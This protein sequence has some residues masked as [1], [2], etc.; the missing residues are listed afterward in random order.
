MLSAFQNQTINRPTQTEYS[1]QQKTTVE[2]HS[3]RVRCVLVHAYDHYVPS[4]TELEEKRARFENGPCFLKILVSDK[5]A[6]CIIG[7]SGLVLAEINDSTG[8]QS[9]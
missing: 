1:L 2:L 6:G 8:E 4:K 9:N 5:A 3:K 7:R